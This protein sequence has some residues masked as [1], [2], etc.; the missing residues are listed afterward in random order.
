LKPYKNKSNIPLNSTRKKPVFSFHNNTKVKKSEEVVTEEPMEIRILSSKNGKDRSHSLA[1]TMRTPGNDRELAAG[2]LFSEGIISDRKDLAMLTHNN[3]PGRPDN[4]NILNVYLKPKIR[5]DPE[6]FLR[7]VYT[8]S[9]CGICGKASLER[10]HSV[11]LKPLTGQLKL[12]PDVFPD[13]LIKSRKAQKV[14]SLTGGLHASALFSKNGDLVL[15]REDVGRH[16]AMDKLIGRLFLK[17]TLPA[18]DFVMFV[19]GRASFELIQKTVMAGIPVLAAVGAPSSLAI[20]LAEDYGMTLIGF[21]KKDR[22]NIYSG[23]Q[24]LLI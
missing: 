17:G 19:S 21:L 6:L 4:H 15:L 18:S 5:F 1:I 22:F 24:R 2:F 20:E 23:H 7:Q 11:G 10:L 12:S 3:V 9:S 14:F 8:T 13:L 16:N